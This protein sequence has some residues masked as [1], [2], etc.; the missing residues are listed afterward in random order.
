MVEY[1]LKLIAE[2]V[3]IYYQLL[4]NGIGHLAGQ[5]MK[6]KQNILQVYGS[7]GSILK[8]LKAGPS[9]GLN[10]SSGEYIRAISFSR[11][12]FLNLLRVCLLLIKEHGQMCP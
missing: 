1:N 8:L 4:S 3:N 12:E 6:L 2:V 5:M 7:L 11:L 10:F 9:K